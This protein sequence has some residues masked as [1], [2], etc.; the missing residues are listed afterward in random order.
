MAYEAMFATKSKMYCDQNPNRKQN[1]L[2]R[3]QTH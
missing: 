1:K 2:Y 3:T